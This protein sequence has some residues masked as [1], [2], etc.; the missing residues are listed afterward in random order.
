MAKAIFMTTMVGGVPNL[1]PFEAESGPQLYYTV[2]GVL[3]GGYSCLGQVPVNGIP[4]ML[5]QVWASNAT[6]DAMDASDEYVFIEDIAEPAAEPGLTPAPELASPAPKSRRK[7][8]E[9]MLA[10]PEPKATKR[11][12][13]RGKALAFLLSHGQA[14]E[15]AQTFPGAVA[16]A[17]HAIQTI[18][19]ITPE[20][21]QHG[22]R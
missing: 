20:Q 3:C 13:N 18:H 6:L 1:P 19:G 10:A 21:W 17:V 7:R 12:F 15:L 9:A 4:S 22:H 16:D 5:V 14:K 8:G 2:D 11:Q